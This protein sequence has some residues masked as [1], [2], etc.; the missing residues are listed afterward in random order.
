MRNP[1]VFRE[2]VVIMPSF[3]EIVSPEVISPRF[4]LFFNG[5]LDIR[6]DN[7]ISISVGIRFHESVLLPKGHMREKQ[8]NS[9]IINI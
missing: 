8:I 4:V 5:G 9:L 1:R 6:I 3:N 2:I 7:I